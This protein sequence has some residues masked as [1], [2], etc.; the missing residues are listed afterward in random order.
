M[1]VVSTKNKIRIVNVIRYLILYYL[2][3]YIKDN[4]I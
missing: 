2:N 4:Y 3:L 1:N